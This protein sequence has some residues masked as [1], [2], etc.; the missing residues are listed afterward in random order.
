MIDLKKSIKIGSV[1]SLKKKKLLGF[2]VTFFSK[3]LWINV[4]ST[5]GKSFN[6]HEG[7]TKMNWKEK[8]IFNANLIYPKL[9][10]QCEWTDM[11][12]YVWWYLYVYA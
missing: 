11:F 2:F 5:K 7:K 12:F 1:S 8:Q 3:Y 6:I 4:M 9:Y 10:N